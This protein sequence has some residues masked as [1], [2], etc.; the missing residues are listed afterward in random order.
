MIQRDTQLEILAPA[1]NTESAMTAIH[2]GANAIYLGFS[3]FSAR[4]GAEN[5]DFAALE[6][7]IA[8]AHFFGVKVYVAMNTLVK[9]E[10]TENF[11]KTLVEVW[12]IG[13][14]AI[15]MQDIFL[16][17]YIHSVYSDIVLHLST[18]AGVCSEEGAR[19]AKE[20]GFSRVILARETP[21]EEMKR[22]SAVIETEAFIQGALC[23]CF[24]G[25]CYFSSFAGGNSGNRGRCKQPCRKKYSY[26]RPHFEDMAYALSLSD[27]C[28]GEKIEKL[29]EAGVT[30][31]KIEGRMR[32]P[33][34][35]GSAVLYYRAL[36]DG[37]PEQE[38]KARFQALK[39][40]Y[41]R[42]N[43]TEGLAFGQDKR[44]LSRAVQGHLGEK[45]GTVKVVNAK[46]FVSST[47]APVL[48]DAFKILRGGA[49]LGGATFAQ[50]GRGGFYVNSR[51]RLLNGDSVFLTTDT[52]S[53]QEVLSIKKQVP[54]SLSLYFKAGEKAWAECSEI[55]GKNRKIRVETDDILSLARS[56][57]LTEKELENCFLKSDC[58][59][60]AVHFKK[61]DLSENVFI[62]KTCLNALRRK[63][64]SAFFDELSK[65]KNT[66]YEYV[67]FECPRALMAKGKEAIIVSDFQRSKKS[68]IYIYKLYNYANPL[69]EDFVKT[70]GEK[71]LYC[72]AFIKR[73]DIETIVEIVK[74]YNFDGIYA[75]N[76]AGIELAKAN[77]FSLFAGVGFNLTN[78]LSVLELLKEESIKYYTISKELNEWEQAAL[79]G[80]NAFV[81]SGGGIKMMDLCYCPFGKT[82]ANCDKKQVYTL[83]DEA[84]RAFPVR[85]FMG[86]NGDCRFEVYNCASLSSS[87]QTFAGKLF[88]ETLPSGK[89]F[90]SGHQKNSVL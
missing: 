78:R 18:Q 72:P 81:L 36:L 50:A 61:V 15:I 56:S 40:A 19:L 88:D 38:K 57:P 12:N 34:Y 2:C 30:S 87:G 64:F 10:E 35:V 84:K 44:L 13:A 45:V 47:Y 51:A 42:G 52:A 24:S 49:E 71:Y 53:N 39:R 37:L 9:D 75:E 79:S 76:Y 21:I 8:K 32:R 48:G 46:Y 20:Y 26:D 29:K 55:G 62:A 83:T 74:K 73:A 14:D 41:N 17:K 63:A 22:I 82:C 43:Y 70:D 3:A 90:T 28:V 31:F 4:A 23:T 11:L 60:L 80:E 6:E 86:A 68:D 7:T 25:Q 27:L 67:A 65:S 5:F 89:N 59:P 66:H 77:G 33:E 54:V 85:R 58:L 69:S 16:G 1:G